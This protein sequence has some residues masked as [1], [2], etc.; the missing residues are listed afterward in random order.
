MSTSAL[1]KLSAARK[2]KVLELDG[3]HI[4]VLEI[5]IGET[6]TWN[7]AVKRIREKMSLEKFDYACEKCSW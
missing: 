5:K 7:E 6:L 3:R 1:G 4:E 2:L